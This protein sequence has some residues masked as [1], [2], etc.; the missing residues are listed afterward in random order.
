[1][2]YIYIKAQSPKPCKNNVILLIYLINIYMAEIR[3][4]KYKKKKCYR[5]SDDK[6]LQK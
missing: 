6:L 1:M 5:N 2:Q 3:I 4:L